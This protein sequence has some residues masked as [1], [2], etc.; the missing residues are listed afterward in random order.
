M[1]I[2][3]SPLYIALAG[4]ILVALSLYVATIRGRYKLPVGD[5]GHADLIGAIRAHGNFIEQAPIALLVI[6]AVDLQGHEKAWVHAL[7]IVLL[8]GRLIH[9]HALITRPQPSV[10]RAIG[11]VLTA[12]VIV[13]GAVLCV[14]GWMGTRL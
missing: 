11:M 13:V 1:R 2:F 7:G 3:D 8:V 14:L 9:A 10:G 6:L 4:L 12:G 5:G